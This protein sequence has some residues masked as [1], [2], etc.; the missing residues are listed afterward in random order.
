MTNKH[1]EWI[2]ESNKKRKK[3]AYA[4]KDKRTNPDAL[5]SQRF[6]I[7]GCERVNPT[8]QALPPISQVQQ[9]WSFNKIIMPPKPS[10]AGVISVRHHARLMLRRNAAHI[11]R[12]VQCSA[13]GM[14]LLILF[15]NKCGIL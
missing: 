12:S 6:L 4:I 5:A 14:V 1:Y 9:H 11:C 8:A 2:G 13:T 3:L 7:Y 15:L 10:E